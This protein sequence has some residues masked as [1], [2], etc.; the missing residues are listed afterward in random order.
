MAALPGGVYRV[1]LA[2]GHRL[3]AF[4]S[5]RR[6]QQQFAPLAAGDPV[7]VQVSP[8]DVSKGAIVVREQARL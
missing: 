6:R 7:T 5:G 2:N 8:F 3:L 4:V 1:E